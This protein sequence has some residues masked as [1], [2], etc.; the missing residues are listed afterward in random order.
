MVPILLIPFFTVNF[1]LKIKMDIWFDLIWFDLLVSASFFFFFIIHFHEHN[2][3]WYN[4]LSVLTWSCSEIITL[5][6]ILAW[7][8]GYRYS[9]S[10]QKTKVLKCV[11][12]CTEYIIHYSSLLSIH[13]CTILCLCQSVPI[14]RPP[15]VF[16]VISCI[17]KR[18]WNH[19][20]NISTI[21]NM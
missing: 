18:K 5:L 11:V 16:K 12:F 14:D 21:L 10:Y 17:W 19:L 9:T 7:N 13:T 8:L 4:I 2:M 20:K 15:N 1:L 3:V 6:I